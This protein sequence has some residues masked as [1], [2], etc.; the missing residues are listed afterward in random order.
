MNSRLLLGFGLLVA[1]GSVASAATVFVDCPSIQVASPAASGNANSTPCVLATPLGSNTFNSLTLTYKYSITTDLDG[2]TATFD[3]NPN[4][5]TL[6]F[7]ANGAPVVLTTP[8]ASGSTTGNLTL[9]KAPTA[10]ELAALAADGSINQQWT[11][12]SVGHTL[13][14]SGDYRWT[15]DYTPTGV[16]EPMTLSMMGIGLLG[17][18]LMRRRQMG[19]K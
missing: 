5:V 18:G 7:W 6:A 10:A 19:K 4:N 14:L 12:V 2:G 16:P 8:P 1:A 17:L 9:S 3:S 13:T 15:L 11:A